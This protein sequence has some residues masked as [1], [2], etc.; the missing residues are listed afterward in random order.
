MQGSRVV[1]ADVGGSDGV[2]M[3][4]RRSSGV[5]GFGGKGESDRRHAPRGPA[6]RQNHGA[7]RRK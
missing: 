6:A 7:G 2:G 4:D 3:F 5:G 1:L